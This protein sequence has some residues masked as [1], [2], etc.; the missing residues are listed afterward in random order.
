MITRKGLVLHRRTG[1]IFYYTM[2]ASALSAIVISLLP[3]HVS[4]FLLGIGLFSSYLIVGG[5][6]AIQF[7]RNPNLQKYMY[8]LAIYILIVGILMIGVPVYLNGKINLVLTV[9]GVAA[10]LFGLRDLRLYKNQAK[11]IQSSMVLHI[12][13][14]VG[15]YIASVTAFLVVNQVLPSYWNWF[16]PTIVL[17]PYIIYQSRKYSSK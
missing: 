2:L 6:L 5:R 3:G 17:T 9:F 14:M 4:Y 15:A 12:G 16:L 1:I 7:R 10:L 11:R 8:W 13:N